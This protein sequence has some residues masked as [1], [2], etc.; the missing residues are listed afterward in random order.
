MKKQ[1]LCSLA[2]VLAFA[3]TGLADNPNVRLVGIAR[4][5]TISLKTTS[6]TVALGAK[7]VVFIF[8]TDFAGTVLGVTYSGATDSSQS[9]TAP[10]GDGLTAIAYTISAGS[11]RVVEIR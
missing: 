6:G 10:S 8:S 4:T 7:S 1:L 3:T 5:P 11:A 2:G 9:F